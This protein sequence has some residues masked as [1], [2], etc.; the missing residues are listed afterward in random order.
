MCA[1]I[2]GNPF[3]EIRGKLAGNVFAR[4]GHGQYIRGY[5]VG[6]NPN[7]VAQATARA[8]FSSIV[9]NYSTLTGSQR[10][11]WQEYSK[12]LFTPR[13]ESHSMQ[14]SG[15]QAFVSLQMA[16]NRSRNLNRDWEFRLDGATTAV[17]WIK[18]DWSSAYS[19]PPE[20]A[21]LLNFRDKS[22]NF[23]PYTL[24]D[25]DFIIGGAC[26]FTI[27]MGTG[28]STYAFWS[29]VDQNSN[30]NGFALYMSNPIKGANY[31]VRNPLYQCLGFFK[32][33]DVVSAPANELVFNELQYRT[34]D[35]FDTSKYKAQPTPGDWV[36]LT[37]YSI[38]GLGQMRRVGSLDK[39]CLF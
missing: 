23:L 35:S 17:P 15:Y 9:S 32:A 5:T 21:K 11:A 31:F 12:R 18:I 1:Y 22:G 29:A 8:S 3:G 14:Y 39:A 16:N 19:E 26:R 25:A 7:T 38:D 10:G 28:D 6:T 30:L 36:R 2:L 27:K 20:T 13:T 34:T 24:V 33:W 37:L 4:N